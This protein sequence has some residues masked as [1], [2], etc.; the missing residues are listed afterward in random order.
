MTSKRIFRLSFLSSLLGRSLRFK[1]FLH[2]E[3]L[4]HPPQVCPSPSERSVKKPVNEKN[5]NE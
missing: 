3:S 5:N 4:D 1:L 2:S